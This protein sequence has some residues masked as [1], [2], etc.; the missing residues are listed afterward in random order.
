MLSTCGESNLLC[1][2]TKKA[3]ISIQ[4]LGRFIAVPPKLGNA[5]PLKHGLTDVTRIHLLTLIT[6]AD[7]ANLP[8]SYF[9]YTSF[10]GLPSTPACY[11][12]TI[13][14]SLVQCIIRFQTSL[15]FFIINCPSLTVKMVFHLTIKADY[16]SNCSS[17]SKAAK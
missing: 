11:K 5:T 14:Y 12:T 3:L 8:T 6:Q 10:T 16:F 7:S 15:I 1:L 13:H 4:K 9:R 17:A 2:Q